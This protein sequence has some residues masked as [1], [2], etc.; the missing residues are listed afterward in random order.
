M[1]VSR[2]QVV[3]GFGEIWS[4]QTLHAYLQTKSVPCEWLDARDVL[5]VVSESE[6]LGEKGS[7]ATG[8]VRPLWEETTRRMSG[9]WDAASERNGFGEIDYA[10]AS[11]ILVVTGFVAV[12]E[13]GAP[14]TL[15]RSG[16]DFSATI[17]AK[18]MAASRVTMWK[19][20]DG[21]YTADP[22]R[23]PEA[24][25]IASL[26]YD[27]AMELA[28]F[29][30]QV[31]HPSAMLPCID[32]SIPV[33][34][35]NIFNPTFPGTVI[36]GRCATLSETDTLMVEEA[37]RSG[38]SSLWD[39]A[40]TPDG[41]TIPIKGITSIDKVAL[42]NL[43]GASLIGVPGV[44][45]KFMVAMS[46]AGINVLLVTQASSDHTLCVAV[47]ED[48]GEKALEA[49]R[50][51]FELEL[52][53]STVG[54]VSLLRGMAIVAIIGEGM[55]F[56]MGVSAT[57]M[58]ALSNAKANVRAIAQGSSERQIAVV[59]AAEQ[60]SR[61]MRSVHQAFT[62]SE[63]IVSVAVVG[64]SGRV[65]QEL[66]SQL[67]QQEEALKRDLQIAVKVV[68]ATSSSKMVCD[69]T[70]MGLE[71]STVL[72]ALDSDVATGLDME[73]LTVAME[74][75]VNPHRVVIDCTS[76]EEVTE[77]YE[78]W[79][80]AGISVI[81]PNKQLGSGPI[82]R[83]RRVASASRERDLAATWTYESSIGAALPIINTAR[84]LVNTGDVVNRVEGCLS[85][86][87]AYVLRRFSAEI[88][89]STAM[90]EAVELGLAETDL[91]L[92]LDGSDTAQK[93]VTLAREVGLEL[94]M[95]D[96]YVESLIPEQISAKAYDESEPGSRQD[97]A[98]G[99][100]MCALNAELLEDVK[101]L[102][103]PML[104][105]LEAAL[106]NGKVLRYGIVIDKAAG[107]GRVEIMEIGNDHPLYRLKADEN[108]VIFHTDRYKSSPLVVKGAAAGPELLASAVFADLLRLSKTFQQ[109]V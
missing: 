38:P 104:E 66:F 61:A 77:Y 36:E 45:Q 28:Y 25:P 96:V 70:M 98:S 102:D 72:D 52:T 10:E 90:R 39:A 16:S 63:T 64:G 82:E 105:R 87:M 6:G 41:Q 107:T 43:E 15:K 12:T 24:F 68:A 13:Q 21:V 1:C 44:A 92:D 35:R 97:A 57:F 109:G 18:L 79:L 81:G 33:Y 80:R 54:N 2:A 37:E 3:T 53:R 11:P 67:A 60:A 58:R 34:V 7:A 32:A 31:L 69:G 46:D 65:G 29:G 88:P 55:A 48:Q 17:F 8:G 103:A 22:R 23:V 89:F 30:A 83:Y 74:D 27:E 100:S 85:Q 94:S 49:V 47:P 62:L 56:R 91:R 9:W 71:A 51:A 4:A 26:K 101:Q 73:E 5:V 86:T 84:D 106:A 75:D 59:M 93:V 19:N 14:T 108:L 42:V 40:T 78:R 76:S 99:G 95:D 50:S 20:T